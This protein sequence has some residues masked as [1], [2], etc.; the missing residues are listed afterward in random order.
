MFLYY[1]ILFFLKE[2]RYTK[3]SALPNILPETEEI[4]KMSEGLLSSS[5]LVF[6]SLSLS[7]SSIIDLIFTDE[8]EER[9]AKYVG[10]DIERLTKD[11]LPGENSESGF[12]KEGE[13]LGGVIKERC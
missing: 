12:I 6:L 10:R 3:D 4:C 5:L 1:F 8:I 11:L 13:R 7:F 9:I 2:E